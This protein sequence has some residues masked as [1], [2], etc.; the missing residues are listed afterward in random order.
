M[1]REPSALARR[2]QAHSLYVAGLEQTGAVRDQNAKIDQ[3]LDPLSCRA[4]EVGE[5]RC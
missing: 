2:K 1:Q 3:S 5:S 4:S